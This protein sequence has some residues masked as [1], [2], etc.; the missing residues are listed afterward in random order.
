[1]HKFSTLRVLFICKD[2]GQHNGKFGLWNSAS[3][4]VDALNDLRRDA[5]DDDIRYDTKLVSVIDGNCIDREVT[6]F[7]PDIVVIEALWVTPNKFIELNAIHKHV[8]WIVRIHSKATFLAQEGIALH[9]VNEYTKIPRVIV[10]ANNS[11]FNDDMCDVG[12]PLL[13]LP[14]IYTPSYKIIKSHQRDPGVINIGCFGALR[15]MKNHLVQAMAAIK[16]AESLGK[17]LHFHINFNCENIDN[18]LRNL[19]SLFEGRK[20]LLKEHGWLRHEDFCRLV[21]SMDVGMQVSVSESFNIVM[22]DFVNLDIPVVCSKEIKFVNWLFKCAN[23]TDEI[24]RTLGL[25]CFGG[26][27]NLQRYNKRLL[28]Q[29]N[30]EAVGIWDRAMHKFL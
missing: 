7:R 5:P 13:Y 20:H 24:V 16:F 27:F 14:N 12:Y 3:F 9:W 28:D 21:S 30:R 6:Q 17:T 15:P 22:A 26:R 8:R 11:E 23:D 25:A 2:R 4:V 10:S 18:V 29:H 19:R 1:M